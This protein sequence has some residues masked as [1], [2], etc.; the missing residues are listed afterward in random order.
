MN[1]LFVGYKPQFLSSNA[2]LSQIKRKYHVKKA[3]F[4]GTLDPFACGTLIIAFGAYTKLF[5]F[6]KK[7][8]K[9]YIATLWLG[10]HSPSLDIEK[11]DRIDEVKKR[12]VQEIEAVLD[13]FVGQ[14]TYTPP[15][16]SAKK[17]GGTR[18]Y[19]MI[20][21]DIA[22]PQVASTIY[23]I[24][25][26][27]YSHPFITFRSVVSEGTYIRSLGEHI[28]QKL[29]TTGA[30]SYLE[31]TREGAFVYEDEKPLDPL[32]FLITKPNS[33]TLS[34]QQIL[35]GKKLKC[36]DLAVCEN[37]IYHLVFD[38]FFTII[39]IENYK[40]KYLLNNLPRS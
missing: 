39:E 19:K 8:P 6:L 34:A 14:F 33:T 29:R 2:Y 38:T 10:A 37:G 22:L 15:K 25:L 20:D 4:S 21:K 7:Y 13:S 12:S 11:I 30:L 18:A 23:E 35:H 28:A 5:R 27:N 36:R 3:G 32:Q 16:Y 31:R 26:L 9:E 1:R 17:V 40:I 24:E